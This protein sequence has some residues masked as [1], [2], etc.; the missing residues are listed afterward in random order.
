MLR[1]RGVGGRGGGADRKMQYNANRG[2]SALRFFQTSPLHPS[3]KQRKLWNECITVGLLGYLVPTASLP[4]DA[5]I[6]G[7]GCWACQSLLEHPLPPVILGDV[8]LLC[9]YCFM[10]LR[11]RIS[12]RSSA[13]AF[14]ILLSRIYCLQD[15]CDLNRLCLVSTHSPSSPRV[16]CQTFVS[17]YW[18]HSVHV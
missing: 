11:G 17:L 15:R 7:A 2:S 5:A 6:S 10:I 1:G 16:P 4:G 8:C 18:L 3:T 14:D 13:L 12:Q 9:A